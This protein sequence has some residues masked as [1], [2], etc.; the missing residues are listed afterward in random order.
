MIKYFI[1]R[2]DK[3]LEPLERQAPMAVADMIWISII[4]VGFFSLMV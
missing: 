1:F 3:K 2:R 4:K